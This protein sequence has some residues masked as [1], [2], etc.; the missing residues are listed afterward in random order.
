[1]GLPKIDIAFKTAAAEAIQRSQKGTV[2]LII[3]D[4]AAVGGRS[5]TN[6]T[7]IPEDWTAANVAYVKQA[8]IGYV[9]PPRKVIVYAIDTGEESTDTLSAALSWMAGQEVDYLAGPPDLTT[10]EAADIATWVAGQRTNY[11][12]VVKAVLPNKAADTEAV[13]NFTGA[14]IMVGNTAYTAAGYCARIAGMA[15]GCPMTIS[16]TYAAVPE[17]TDITRMTESAMDAAIDA[18]QL[19]LLHDG[20]K[21]KIA[22]GV[23]SLTTVTDDHGS[24]FKKIKIVEAMD[25]IQHDIRVTAQDSYIGKYANSYDNKLL[26]VSAIKGYFL[27]LELE[28]LLEPGTSSVEIDTEAQEA[29]LVSIGVDTTDMTEQEIREHNTGDKVFLKAS[30]TILDT[31]EEIK[32]NITI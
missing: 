7:Q 29:Y 22:R 1:M 15:A 13:V 3:R 28:N 24:Q 4:A 2:G 27:Q 30:I 23:N 25:M 19:I 18:G 12:S 10:T 31:I 11:H 32:L 14:G 8:F 26:L 6:I 20:Q 5:L 21:V 16:L 9:N 17:I